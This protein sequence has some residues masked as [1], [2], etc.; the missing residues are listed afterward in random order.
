MKLSIKNLLIIFGIL[1]VAFLLIRLNKKGGKS[2]ALRSELVSIDTAK[3][4]KI[5]ISSPKGT[6]KLSKAANGWEV[7]LGS[8]KK[9]ARE[10]SIKNMLSTL[11]TIKPGRLAA[12]KEDKWKD[13]AVDSAG[14]RVQV[15]D[16][17][18]IL[19]D[20]VLGRFGVQGQQSFYTFVRLTEDENVY[21][22]NNFMKMSILEEPNDYRNSEL[23]SLQKDSLVSVTFDYPDSAFT[24]TKSTDWFLS[25]QQADSAAVATF[26]QGLS[27]V[28]SKSFFDQP[29][30]TDPTHTIT[31][32]FADQPE[33][34]VEGYVTPSNF[35]IR[36]SANKEE[37]FA[38][39]SVKTKVFKGEGVFV[40]TR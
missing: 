25:D 2:K 13:Y 17:D 20:I 5:E 33:L 8:E 21:V 9:A 37:S 24:L 35:V 1:A 11:N 27:Y 28:S 39:E 7:A 30:S 40:A 3:V 23:F 38:D 32:S 26:L 31:F 10:G 36:S 12:R 16:G 15:F 22:A 6:V 29:V 4:S 34:V 14:T 19:T 18:N